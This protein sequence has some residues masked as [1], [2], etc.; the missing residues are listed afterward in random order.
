M[1]KHG[2]NAAVKKQSVIKACEG[3]VNE[4]TVQIWSSFAETSLKIQ[5]IHGHKSVSDDVILNSVLARHDQNCLGFCEW[6]WCS[7]CYCFPTWKNWDSWKIGWADSLEIRRQVTDGYNFTCIVL[8]LR[9]IME[10]FWV[11]LPFMT[12]NGSSV[13]QWSAYTLHGPALRPRSFPESGVRSKE[14]KVTVWRNSANVIHYLS[15]I[16]SQCFTSDSWST[17]SRDS[18]RIYSI[19]P[20]SRSSESLRRCC[21]AEMPRFHTSQNPEAVLAG[22][23]YSPLQIILTALPTPLLQV[24]ANPST[25]TSSLKE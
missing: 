24:I 1:L 5:P 17:K 21:T 11:M 23:R 14:V 3:V 22:D 6:A 19:G 25:S 7:L 8:N 20:L 4:N 9:I 18:A 13:R 2:N 10:P 12:R 15:L 16:A